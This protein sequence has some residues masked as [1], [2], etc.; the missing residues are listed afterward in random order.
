MIVIGK[1]LLDL[2]RVFLQKKIME[3]KLN[4]QHKQTNNNERIT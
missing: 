3:I 4:L 1:R 2:K